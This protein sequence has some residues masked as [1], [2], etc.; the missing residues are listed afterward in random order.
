MGQGDDAV[1]PSRR[2]T[3]STGPKLPAGI[4]GRDQDKLALPGSWPRVIGRPFNLLCVLAGE[5]PRRNKTVKS[6]N[7]VVHHSRMRN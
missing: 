4:A 1:T 2:C 5:R 6:R 3:C 7:R